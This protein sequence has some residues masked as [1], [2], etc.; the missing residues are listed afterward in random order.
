MKPCAPHENA[1]AQEL[2]VLRLLRSAA[3]LEVEMV[4]QFRPTSI[5]RSSVLVRVRRTY[6]L[7]RWTFCTS[8]CGP[9]GMG[10]MSLFSITEVHAPVPT[11][12]LIERRAEM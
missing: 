7:S 8:I 5:V 10:H 11:W 6:R 3:E 1:L 4:P 9:I 2:F 12:C